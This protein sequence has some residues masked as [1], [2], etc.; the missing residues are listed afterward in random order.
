MGVRHLLPRATWARSW[1]VPSPLRQ[2]G[3]RI[4][5][6]KNDIFP[7]EI[8]VAPEAQTTISDMDEL[9]GWCQREKEAIAWL[10]SAATQDNALSAVAQRHAEPLESIGSVIEELRTHVERGAENSREIRHKLQ[11]FAKERYGNAAEP[12]VLTSHE[13]WPALKIEAENNPLVAGF[14]LARLTRMPAAPGG[15]WASH[16]GTWKADALINGF[17]GNAES[18]SAQL[19]DLLHR[20]Q[21]EL[22]ELARLRHQALEDVDKAR[23]QSIKLGSVVRRAAQILL[24]RESTRFGDMLSDSTKTLSNL[25][26]TYERS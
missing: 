13:F 10:K 15:N 1:G 3:T 23:S 21:N 19:A 6:N 14:M 16:A 2:Q 24:K 12:R 9:I 26:E 4:L 17:Q 8:Q 22:A 20:F 18:Q 7:F 5:K 11:Q 25:E